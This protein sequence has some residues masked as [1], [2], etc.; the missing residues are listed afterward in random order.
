M[1]TIKYR[2]IIDLSHTITEGIP[3]WPGN[4]KQ[5]K[6]F[7][8]QIISNYKENGFLQYY[9]NLAEHIGT[10]IDAPLH[11]NERNYSIDQLPLENLISSGYVINVTKQISIN[12]DYRL[13]VED[14]LLWEKINGS[15][16]GNSFIIMQSDWSEYWN[17]PDKYL[18]MDENGKMHFP[19]FS[20][21]T[22]EFLIKERGV[23]GI[24]VETMS[25]DAGNSEDFSVHKTLFNY[26]KYAIEN[27][28]NIKLLPVK[29][30]IIVAIP[31]KIM[32]GTGSPARV[33]ALI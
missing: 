17:Q 24:G 30:F 33:L 26:N 20:K 22:V 8:K 9:L 18:N 13:Q 7:L 29:N 4:G 2:K 3:S 27:L 32:N 6:P 16:K 14:I 5:H 31:L 21:E 1:H 28:K 19:G 25:I 12:P 10:H 11:T 15:I 23:N